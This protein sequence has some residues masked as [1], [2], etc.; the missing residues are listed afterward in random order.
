MWKNIEKELATLKEV[1][2]DN[3]IKGENDDNGSNIASLNKYD[4]Y[5]IYKVE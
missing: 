2:H 3:G 5:K 4:D 1:H